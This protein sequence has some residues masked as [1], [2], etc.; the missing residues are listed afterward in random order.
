[1]IH[2]STLVAIALLA[3]STSRYSR[4]ARAVTAYWAALTLCVRVFN[5]NVDSETGNLVDKHSRERE[6]ERAEA[7]TTY[8]NEDGIVTR[9]RT[10]CFCACRPSRMTYAMST[11]I[12]LPTISIVVE[13]EV[14]TASQTLAIAAAAD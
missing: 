4:C 14:A 10:S 1:M 3:R 12:H 2:T 8:R 7:T 9:E 5:V 6:R 11:V 13:G